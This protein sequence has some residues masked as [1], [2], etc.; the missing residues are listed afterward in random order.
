MEVVDPRRVVDLEDAPQPPV[1]TAEQSDLLWK[2]TID[3]LDPVNLRRIKEYGGRAKRGVLLTGE[4]G[5]GKTM[6]CR[7]IWEECR[8]RPRNAAARNRGSPVSCAAS[9]RLRPRLPWSCRYS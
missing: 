3:Y 7:W 5:N 1:L 9:A 8:R 2:N 4:P 6:A